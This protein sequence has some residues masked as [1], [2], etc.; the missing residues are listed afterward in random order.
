M[1]VSIL[2]ARGCPYKCTYCSNH[3]LQLLSDGK[4][5]RYRSPGD[6]NEGIEEVRRLYPDLRDIYL[7]V[8]TIG[9]SM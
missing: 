7:E 2:V 8:E 6:M 5:V 1:K 4:L 3:A 9:A